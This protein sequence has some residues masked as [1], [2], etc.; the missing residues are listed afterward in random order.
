[1]KENAVA[2]RFNA[3]PPPWSA[4][5]AVLAIS[6]VLCLFTMALP[7]PCQQS[8][9]VAIV[10]GEPIS[11][12]DL[13]KAAAGQ[14]LPLRNQEYEIESKALD[15]LIR[16]K[17]LES[18]A[19]QQG[20]SPEALLL[21][22]ADSTV[23]DPTDQEVLAYYL[24]QPDRNRQTF[25]QVKTQLRAALRRAKVLYARD[26]YLD[27]LRAQANVVVLLNPSRAAVNFDPARM[28]GNPAAPV[29]IVEFSD[30]QC[31][32]CRQQE[33]ILARVLAKYG[34]QVALS[35]RDFPVSGLHPLAW[36]AAEASR[37]GGEQGKY[38]QLF[39]MLMTGGLDTPSL[40]RY[41]H[42]L[43]LDETQFDRCLTGDQY[44]AA[45]QSDRQDAE[46]LGVAATP[47]FFINGIS[48][49][50]AESEEAL[51]KVIDQELARQKAPPLP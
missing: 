26:A 30:F 35:Y 37:C 51:S 29:V 20:V 33:P 49:V 43:K 31:P 3:R 32:F 9:P 5:R 36:Q 11:A 47:T 24:A 6:A 15:K 8:Q 34:A 21:R 45:I 23:A 40:K 16:Q 38:W 28:K 18:A 10:D 13:S 7:A 2:C 46:N 44:K 27:H 48:M 25:D 17:L 41:A 1:M 12:V 4:G 50:D 42:D 39:E 14:L 19:R 22:Q